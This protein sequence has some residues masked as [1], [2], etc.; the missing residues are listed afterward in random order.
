MRATAYP[1]EDPATVPEPDAVTDV[2]VELAETACK[3]HGE[4][5]RTTGMVDTR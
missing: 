4:V 3:R 2:F 5:V 1:G